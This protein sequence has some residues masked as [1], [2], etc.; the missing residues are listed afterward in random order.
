MYY[1][2]VTAEQLF[3]YTSLKYGILVLTE[4]LQACSL[5]VMLRSDF[6]A[7]I[8]PIF[9]FELKLAYTQSAVIGKKCL[10]LFVTVTLED[11]VESRLS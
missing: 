11:R 3:S 8:W 10:L 6:G 2:S 1:R 5:L 4:A 9:D 7:E